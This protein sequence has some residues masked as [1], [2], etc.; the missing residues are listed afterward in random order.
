MVIGGVESN[1]LCN[2][3]RR[4]TKL[5]DRASHNRERRSIF[6]LVVPLFLSL[7]RLIVIR[8]PV[9]STV[10]SNVI[11]LSGSVSEILHVENNF[12]L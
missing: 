12:F 10:F 11:S 3:T 8:T 9:K 7:I 6:P 4:I 1:S 2:H 5:D